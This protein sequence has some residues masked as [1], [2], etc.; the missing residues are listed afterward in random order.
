MATRLRGRPAHAPGPTYLAYTPNGKKLITVGTNGA[1]RIFQHGSDD[2]PAIIDVTTDN[3]TAVVATNTFFLVGAEDGSVTKYSLLTNSMEEILVR[4]SLPVRDLSLSRDG[5]W[6]AVASDELEVK[7]VDTGDMTRIMHLREQS[8]PVKH[9]SFDVS[10]SMLAVSCSD[11]VVYMYSLSSEQPQLLKRIDGLVKTLETDAEASSKVAWHPDGRAFVAPTSTRDIQCLAR[12]DWQ[13]QK[14][15]SGGHRADISAVK[16]SPNG[17]LLATAGVDNSLCIWETRS[18]RLVKTFE[19][20]NHTILALN[21]HPTDN[22]C[23]YTNHNG[24]LFIREDFVPSPS[25]SLLKIALH[26]APM[27]N[28]PLSKISGN[29]RKQADD[30]QKPDGVHRSVE[31]QYLDDLLGPDAMSEDDAG[32][33]ED[34]D[35]AG[36]A[37]VPNGFGKR[38]AGAVNGLPVKRHQPYPSW[39]PQ[40]QEAF[41]PGSTPWRGNRRYLCLNLTGFVWTVNQ[42]THHTVTVEFYDRQEHRDFHFTDPY[43]YDKACLNEKGTLFSC[44]PSAQSQQ[45]A[46]LYYRPHETW[47]T[48]MEWKTQLPAGELVI[49][50]S[51]SDSCIVVMT[52]AGYVRVYTLFGVPLLVHR[53]K[54]TPAV[55]C[56]SFRDYVMTVGT[57][58]VSGDGTTRL[59]YS[60]ENV[61]RDEICQNEDVLA[62]PEGVELRS[63]FF[64]DKGDPCIYDTSGVLLTLLHWRTPGQAKWVPLLDTKMLERLASGKKDET[65]WPVAVADNKFHCIILKGGEEYPYFPRPL[66]SD[67]DFNIPV[68]SMPANKDDDE[69]KELAHQKGLEEQFVRASLQHSLQRDL[70]ENTNASSAQKAEV[71]MMERGVDKVLLQMLAAECRE[72]EERGMKAL[73]IAALMRDRTGK[74][75]EAAGKIASR[76]QRDILGD[77]IHQLAERRLVGL[78]D[79]EEM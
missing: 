15:F 50:M 66:L 19:D 34:D 13:R 12:K 35:G 32:F 11:G 61:R 75:L 48:R 36:Y 23:S 6:V 62:L 58:P 24:E 76:F 25:S 78:V 49:S 37:E 47:T 79:E 51:L 27:N 70:V 64:S 60:I 43:K 54:S 2:E 28:E 31:D 7:V 17:A 38:A 73:E 3:H 16:W 4:C 18:Q 10:G 40:V 77:K 69:D 65:Y 67:F 68:S 41:Q 56:A 59:L 21:W 8:R 22:L 26:P 14:A 5:E 63:V 30:R 42:E 74:M 71:S 46:T 72:G 29:A 39:R 1:V 9:V 55:T 20:I 45:S 57:G 52:T 53:Q 33:I 44:P